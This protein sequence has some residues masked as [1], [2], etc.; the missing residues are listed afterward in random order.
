MNAATPLIDRYIKPRIYGR[1][2]QGEPLMTRL[3]TKD[4]AGSSTRCG[5]NSVIRPCCS[6]AWCS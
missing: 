5:R 1:T 6:A 2:R 4:A 3:A